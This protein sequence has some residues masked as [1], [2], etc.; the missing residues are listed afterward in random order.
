MGQDGREGENE[1][2]LNRI[3]HGGISTSINLLDAVHTIF[4]TGEVMLEGKMF[5]LIGQLLD[6]AK[7]GRQDGF[8]KIVW[9]GGG[10]LGDGADIQHVVLFGMFFGPGKPK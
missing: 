3:F 7:D 10:L 1:N 5:G 8:I 9:F 4:Q 6:G 2:I